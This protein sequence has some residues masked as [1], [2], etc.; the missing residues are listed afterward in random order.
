MADRK[1]ADEAYTFLIGEDWSRADKKADKLM[2]PN[3]FTAA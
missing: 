3:P 1:A 2:F